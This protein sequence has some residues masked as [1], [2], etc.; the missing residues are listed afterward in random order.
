MSASAKSVICTIVRALPGFS[1][2]I[3]IRR[4]LRIARRRLW[5]RLLSEAT[6]ETR[7]QAPPHSSVDILP[8]AL[9][10]AKPSDIADPTSRTGASATVADE[11]DSYPELRIFDAIARLLDVLI[12]RIEKDEVAEGD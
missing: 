10:H 4:R 7:L 2:K 8:S 11:I 6:G 12:D 1:Y 3:R 5:R 9:K